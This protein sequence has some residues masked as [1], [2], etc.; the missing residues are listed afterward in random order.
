M[1]YH[2]TCEVLIGN[3]KLNHQAL[4]ILTILVIIRRDEEGSVCEGVLV[5]GAVDLVSST[6]I[7]EDESPSNEVDMFLSAIGSQCWYEF[8]AREMRE[9]QFNVI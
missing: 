1:G 4:G 8:P 6:S 7:G 5:T 9:K 3:T 2:S